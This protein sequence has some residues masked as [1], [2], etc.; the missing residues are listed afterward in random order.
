MSLW[1]DGRG[2]VWGRKRRY[3]AGS[4]AFYLWL[5]CSGT[6]YKESKALMKVFLLSM[7]YFLG[8]NTYK[9]KLGTGP[10]PL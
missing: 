7:Y 1:K 2:W 9:A 3:K 6:F 4:M 10:F 5:A 8:S